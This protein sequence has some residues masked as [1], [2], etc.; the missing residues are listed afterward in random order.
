[1]PKTTLLT[2]TILFVFLSGKSQNETLYREDFHSNSQWEQEASGSR[3][4]INGVYKLSSIRSEKRLFAAEEFCLNPDED[5]YI[6]ASL[7]HS[8]G[9][10]KG[11][12]GLYLTD[13]S[14]FKNLKWQYFLISADH[15]YQIYYQTQNPDE[16]HYLQEETKEKIIINGSGKFNQLAIKKE[17][18]KISF[19]INDQ[20]VY[21]VNNI[22]FWGQMVGFYADEGLAME[23]DY[24]EIRQKNHQ[25]KEVGNSDETF[26]KEDLKDSINT[27]YSEL[28]PLI[29]HDGQT[30]YFVRDGDPVNKGLQNLQDIWTSSR[31]PNGNWSG[32]KNI[33]APLNND[34]PNFIFSVLPDGNTI[35]LGNTYK[36]DGSYKGRGISSSRRVKSGWSIPVDVEIADYYNDYPQTSYCLS[37]DGQVLISTL[38]REDSRGSLDLYVSF[39]REDGTFSEPL[40]MGSDLNTFG[41]EMTPFLAADG[42]TLYF[43]SSG[44][45][46]MGGT[47]I[48]ISRRLDSSWTKW[49]EPQNL[50]PELNTKGFDAYYSIPAQGDYAYLVSNKDIY[51]IKVVE[52]AK[53]DPVV[54]ISGKV[55]NSKTEE[56][57]ESEIIYSDLTTGKELG[58]ANS[59][60]EN[61]T[62]KIILPYGTNYG[63]QAQKKGYYALSENLNLTDTAQ[64]EE[65]HKD[66]YLTPIE[67]GET[68]ILNNI[69]FGYDSST[70]LTESFEELNKLVETLNDN[71]DLTIKIKGHT[72]DVGGVEYNLI[73]SQKRAGSVVTYLKEKGIDAKRLTSEGF[74]KSQPIGDNKTEEG[75]A[76]N[77]RVEFEILTK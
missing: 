38:E 6:E 56:P 28:A 47:D 77:R 14:K 72:D 32:A 27:S 70:L 35:L 61:G 25:L 19:F 18:T 52:A 21:H 10:E 49:S 66:L 39:R 75:R 42:K 73:L 37:A 17:G 8:E 12:F 26:I 33:G 68:I 5:F 53:P 23:V 43:A 13:M 24:L 30:L 7:K 64:F 59:S 16:D 58:T 62:F 40:N 55:L 67:T 74:G 11:F 51:R 36:P 46:G 3:E 20:E 22:K 50:G 31:L 63:F 9:S 69:F 2:L 60:P 15:T 45:P 29:S 4:I 57:L 71:P 1:M 44:H 48:F 76:K 34:Q 41:R 54:I 65:I